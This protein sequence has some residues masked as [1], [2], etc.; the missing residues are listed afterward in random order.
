MNLVGVVL[1]SDG[2]SVRV[3]VS[4]GGGCGSCSEKGACGLVLIQPV[5]GAGITDV[6]EADNPV[7]ARPGDSVELELP[8][9][10]ELGVSA[11]VWGLPIL[12]L[13]GGAVVAGAL[14]HAALGLDQDLAVLCGALLG[15]VLAYGLLRLV[16]RR[17][18]GHR[19]LRPRAIRL[20]QAQACATHA[21][22][23]DD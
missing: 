19:R 20:V 17:A 7:G 21:R 14:G 12:G 1:D 15:L 8:A 10:T 3:A 18:A 6:V 2:D 9:G 16:D 11:L 5:G 4:P 13:V 23:D 22:V